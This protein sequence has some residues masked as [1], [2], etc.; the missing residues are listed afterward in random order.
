MNKVDII[1]K[2][3]NITGFSYEDSQLFLETFF[4]VLQNSFIEGK[5]I[6]FRK[7]GSF[8]LKKRLSKVARNINNNEAIILPEHVVVTFQPSKSLKEAIKKIHIS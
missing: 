4:K 6:N 5:D 8:K 2:V 1:K 3:A 7:F